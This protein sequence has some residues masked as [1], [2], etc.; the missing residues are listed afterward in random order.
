MVASSHLLPGFRKELEGVYRSEAQSDRAADCG[1]A[2]RLAALLAKFGSSPASRL[3]QTCR[4]TSVPKYGSQL[5]GSPSAVH[6]AT[7]ESSWPD[8]TTAPGRVASRSRMAAGLS[9]PKYW[10]FRQHLTSPSACTLRSTATSPDH[11][12]NGRPV[13]FDLFISSKGSAASARS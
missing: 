1:E 10:L 4:R 2:S 5:D 9:R 3:L 8:C 12:R 13:C 7:C 6:L 11:V